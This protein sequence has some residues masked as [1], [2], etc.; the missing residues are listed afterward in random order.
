MINKTEKQNG[1]IVQKSTDEDVKNAT[2]LNDISKKMSSND[3]VQFEDNYIQ[4][5]NPTTVANT[6]EKKNIINND[7]KKPNNNNNND[8]KTNNNTNENKLANTNNNVKKINNNNDMSNTSRP[9][10]KI[11]PLG[12]LNEIGKNMTVFEYGN[13]IVVLDCGLAFPTDEMLGVDLVIPDITY[14]EKNKEKVRAIVLTHGH[15]DHIGAIPYFLRKIQVPIY[16]TKLTLGL[17]KA[18]LIEHKLDKTTDFRYVKHREII[19]IGKMKIEFIRVT[20]SIADASAIA[21]TT[22]EGVVIHTGDFKVDFTP[23]DG[24]MIDLN[25]FAELGN[26][27]VTLLMSDSTNVERP[28]YTM[29]EKNVGDEFDR[30]F[31]NCNKRIIVATFSSNIHRMQQVINTAV[32]CKRKVAVVGR[33]MVN[34]I[35]VGTELG[36]ITAPEG[37]IID[38]DKVGIY[39]P[40][41]L[42]I[43]TTGS[44]GEPMSALSR[45]AV[46]EHRKIAI[47][48]DD[49]VIFSSSAIPGNEKSINRVID[50]LEKLGAEVIYNQLA[51]VHV[52][53]HACQEELKLMLNLTKP[54]YF[55][56]VH[57]EFRF[58]KHH[59]KLAAT[60]GTPKENI[61]IMENGKSLEISNGV[62][63]KA[64]QVPSGI[65]FIDGL[66][67]GDVGNIVVKDRQLLSENGMIIV[68]ITMD[69]KTANIVAGPEIV[70]RGFVYVRE[71]EELMEEIKTVAREELELCIRNKQFEWST[72]KSNVRESLMSY[73]Y[74]KIK[75]EPMILPIISEVDIETYMKN[76]V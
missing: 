63:K 9:K 68:I 5:K 65:V 62:V 31:L 6:T 72:I 48:P 15:E 41:Q 30:L 73:I 40:E 37:T 7:N 10:L 75:R 34:V 56:P 33:S 44:Q 3:K 67:V 59:G 8:K 32:K 64:A 24:E 51:D 11:I 43:I 70:T 49:L 1:E 60:M 47:N 25:R 57:G 66:G 52:S 74:K 61:F 21:I 28:G 26:Q 54:K 27:G 53:G 58:L 17:V 22:P 55:M 20:H 18:K 50:E 45:M 12:G 76:K 2:L 19:T 4:H 35:K 13:D 39:N 14:L 36:Y 16:G 71:S 23:I 42:V 46:G 38:I 29:S 69:R